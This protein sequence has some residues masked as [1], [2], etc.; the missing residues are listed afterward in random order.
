MSVPAYI[1][2]SSVRVEPY[3]ID[4]VHTTPLLKFNIN[5]YYRPGKAAMAVTSDLRFNDSD[6]TITITII[7]S[8]R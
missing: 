6:L 8:F 7:I 1:R 2:M 4:H 3:I 5:N